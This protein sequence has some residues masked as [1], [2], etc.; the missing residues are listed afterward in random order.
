MSGGLAVALI[1]LSS[2]TL[3]ILLVPLLLR[4][5]G[6]ASRDAYNLAV[7][8]DQLAEVERDLARGLIAGD[9]AE[10]ARTE[11]SRRILAL[12]PAEGERAADP[13]PLAAAAVAIL[14]LPVAAWA[15]YWRLGSP[16]MPD[17]PFAERHVAATNPVAANGPHID[18]NEAI[19]KLGAH[20]KQH[21][22]DLTGW[23]LLARSELSLGHYPEGA[24]AYH[25]AVDLS[26]HRADI[27]GDWGEAQV[28]A[29]DGTVTPAARE[30]FEAAL[31]DPE[32]APRARYYLALA[33]FQQGD[34]K[35][36]IDAWT[37]LAADSPKDAEWLPIVQQR[38]AQATAALRLGLPPPKP[39]A[40]AKDQPKPSR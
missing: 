21:P 13:K 34:I 3:A 29:A 16:S 40:A 27:L 30:A 10:A 33:Q 5:G 26:G 24:D 32:T 36:A 7:Y 1:G 12:H 37:A 14:L 23:L 18:L 22:E 15:I 20:L 17:R 9:Q 8:R 19:A 25:H 31:K 39:G 2:L 35:G 28:L 4:R 38:I 6:P 11:I